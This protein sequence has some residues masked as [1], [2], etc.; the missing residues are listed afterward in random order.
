MPMA[1]YIED[2]DEGFLERFRADPYATEDKVFHE[3]HQRLATPEGLAQIKADYQAQLKYVRARRKTQ[4]AP[5]LPGDARRMFDLVQ[6]PF[7]EILGVPFREED[8]YIGEEGR[9]TLIQTELQ[10]QRNHPYTTPQMYQFRLLRLRGLGTS[11]GHC[12]NGRVFVPTYSFHEAV[13]TLAHEAHH[14]EMTNRDHC[15]T[16]FDV[17]NTEAILEGGAVRFEQMMGE[18]LARSTGDNRFA[19]ALRPER[20]LDIAELFVYQSGEQWPGKKQ[21]IRKKV[22]RQV[23]RAVPREQREEAQKRIKENFS[24]NH[25]A[26]GQLL[27]KEAEKTYDPVELQR[28]VLKGDVSILFN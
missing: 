20:L 23:M 19:S 9:D 27:F 13:L 25:Y 28:T 15:E 3:L 11:K 7:E 5:F 4:F 16:D 26:A 2:V 10:R 12:N 18:Y 1:H 21:P 24:F 8:I 22:S 6:E 14:R 17:R